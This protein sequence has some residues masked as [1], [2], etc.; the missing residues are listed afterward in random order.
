M[1]FVDRGLPIDVIFYASVWGRRREKE[2]GEG[3][4][5]STCHGLC[6]TALAAPTVTQIY[7]HQKGSG[8]RQV[9]DA[10]AHTSIKHPHSRATPNLQ[11]MG[12][13]T[14]S[15]GR[16]QARTSGPPGYS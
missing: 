12:R 8:T 16:W 9:A 7:S 13:E 2:R 14:G 11:E 1:L 15:Q 5:V 4:Q 10:E 3:K 6:P